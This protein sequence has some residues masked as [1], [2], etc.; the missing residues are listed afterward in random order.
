MVPLS[1]RYYSPC[2]FFYIRYPVSYCELEELLGEII[3]RFK[4][5]HRDG[6][7]TV[8]MIGNGQLFREKHT[9]L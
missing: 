7:E 5:N 1:E 9:A 4:D 2:R 3:L 6:I 8:H